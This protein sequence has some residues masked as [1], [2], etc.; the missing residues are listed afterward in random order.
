MRNWWFLNSTG[1]ANLFVLDLCISDE[2]KTRT[3]QDQ[4]VLDFDARVDVPFHQFSLIWDRELGKYSYGAAEGVFFCHVLS[5]RGV[6]ESPVDW[7]S[8]LFV[9]DLCISDERKTQ[10][11]AGEV[12]GRDPMLDCPCDFL[13]NRAKGTEEASLFV[14]DLCIFDERKTRDDARPQVVLD[15]EV[16]LNVQS[17]K[18]DE[19]FNVLV[20]SW[21]TGTGEVSLYVLDLCMSGERKTQG[22]ICSLLLM[23]MGILYFTVLENSMPESYLGTRSPCD[24]WLGVLSCQFSFVHA[25]EE[26]SHVPNVS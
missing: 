16:R 12:L 13:V 20:I 22:S 2:R 25:P 4:G 8:K 17:R 9:L 10:D 5:S 3:M 21:L 24:S 6:I 11:T 23:Y 19:V 18:S 15:F 7:R 1:E 14:L 26:V